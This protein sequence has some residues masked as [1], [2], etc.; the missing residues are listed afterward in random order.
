[1]YE[2]V[3]VCLCV[4]VCACMHEC[5]C[6][7]MCVCMHESVSVCVPCECR[8]LVKSEEGARPKYSC[9]HSP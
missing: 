8:C 9:N 6:V 2:C 4:C 1:M 7:Y 5:V 3:C